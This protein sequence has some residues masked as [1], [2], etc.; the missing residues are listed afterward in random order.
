MLQTYGLMCAWAKFILRSDEQKFKL[1][2]LLFFQF[3]HYVIDVDYIGSI[4]NFPKC[5]IKGDQIEVR[6]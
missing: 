1:I 4:Q 5:Q 6:I 3:S 2:T